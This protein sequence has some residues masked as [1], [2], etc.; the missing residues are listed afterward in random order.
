[1]NTIEMIIVLGFWAVVIAVSI[2]DPITDNIHI[3]ATQADA[4]R[5]DS[6][7]I[8]RTEIVYQEPV[9]FLQD[10]KDE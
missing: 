6:T 7:L 5:S 8:I 2:L 1:M 4:I 3:L 10:E 9:I